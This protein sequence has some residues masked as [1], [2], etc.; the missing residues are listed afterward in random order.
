MKSCFVQCFLIDS[1]WPQKLRKTSLVLSLFYKGT[2]ELLKASL[3]VSGL[4]GEKIRIQVFLASS[5][6]IATSHQHS[7][8]KVGQSQSMST[9]IMIGFSR[10]PRVNH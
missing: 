6:L 2:E 10:K 4:L 3:S 1:Q 5:V 9:K 8:S 7:A